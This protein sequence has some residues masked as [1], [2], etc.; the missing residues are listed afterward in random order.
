MRDCENTSARGAGVCSLVLALFV[1][2]ALTWASPAPEKPS[3][4]ASGEAGRAAVQRALGSNELQG[5]LAA[6]DADRLLLFEVRKDLPQKRADADIYLKRLK[7]LAARSDP[8]LLVPKVNRMI[9]QAPIYYDWVEKNI[10]NQNENANEYVV[11]GARGFLVA[12]QD[13]QNE[14]ML[15]VINRLEIAGNAIREAAALS[16]G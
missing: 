7:E 14:V 15:I 6:M 13:F 1:V 4:S 12:F 3:G 2:P 5:F 9:E 11:G 16:P 8:A 10:Q